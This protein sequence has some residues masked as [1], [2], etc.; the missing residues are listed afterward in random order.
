MSDINI[1]ELTAEQKIRLAVVQGLIAQSVAQGASPEDI[2]DATLV[3]A[4]AVIDGKA[5]ATT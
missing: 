2:A 4:D 1:H 3:I 5:P